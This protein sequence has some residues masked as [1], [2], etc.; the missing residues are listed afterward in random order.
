MV[1]CI[2]CAHHN[3]AAQKFCGECGAPLPTDSPSYTPPHLQRTVLT[4][5]FAIEGERKLVT[6]MFCDIA[7]S[8][9]LAASVGAEAMHGMLNRFFD[10]ALAD[11]HRYEGTINQFLG[12]G[13]M[14]LFGAPIAHED[15][16]R[17]A[18]LAALSIQQRVR[19]MD[20][21]AN[22][23]IQ[24]RM[25]L[26]TGM[27]VV[28][29]IGDNLRMDYTAVGDTTHLAARLQSRADPGTIRVAEGTR[30]AAAAHFAF[31]HLGRQ[32]LKGIA[33]PVD[34]FEPLGE[35]AGG[36]AV[37][38][39]QLAGVG[40][41]LVGRQ[42]ELAAL[43][44][45]FCEPGQRHGRVVLIRGEPG[46][47][48]S[49][50]LAEARRQ[51]PQR[52]LCLEGR[53]V[54]FGRS[55]SYW[56]FMQ[57]LRAALEITEGDAE[58]EALRKLEAQGQS[59]F[60]PQAA[61]VVPYLATLLSIGLSGEHEKRVKFLDAQAMKRQVFL[62][63]RQLFERL[64]Q[65]Q[66]V[67][68]VLEDWH[69]VDQSSVS[70]LEHLLP[71]AASEP[72]S[73][74]LTSR[75][76]PTAPLEHL[77][78]STTG[79]PGMHFEE[80]VLSPLS[81][82]HSGALIGAI[83]GTPGLPQTVHEQIQRRTAGN[84]FFIEEVIRAL[85]GDGTLTRDPRDGSWRLARP[86]A[87]VS[88]PDT[89]HALLQARID[90]LEDSVKSVL[91]LASVIG[92]SFF[93]RV[94]KSV[95]EAGDDVEGGL[96]RLE[97]EQ[98][99]QLLE[100]LPELEYVFRHAL[101]QE[102]AYD[103]ILGERRKAIH[104]SVARAIES[105]FADRRDEYA[106]LLAYHFARAE[107]WPSAQVYLLAA[108]DQAGRI[109]ADAEALEHYRQ[110]EAT[111]MKVAAR[112]LTPLLRASMERKLGQAFYG[113]GN[114]DEAVAHLTN[115]LAYLGIDYPKSRA[116]VRF[117]IARHIGAHFLRR[118][119]GRWMGTTMSADAAQEASAIA[120]SLA[121][122]DYYAD[123]DRFALDSLIALSTGERSGDLASTTRGIATLGLVLVMLGLHRL[124]RQRI[125][126]AVATA[127][128]ANV[129]EAMAGALFVRGWFEWTGGML[130]EALSS[131][132]QAASAYQSIGDLRGWAGASSTSGWVLARRGHFAQAA[133]LSREI[134]RVGEGAKDPHLA[135]WGSVCLGHLC[136]AVGP[137]QDA[138]PPLEKV[139]SLSVRTSAPRMHANAGGVLAKSLLRRGEIAQ[140]RGILAHALEVLEARGMKD[141]FF[142]EPITAYA[143]LLLMEADRSTGAAR[144]AALRA[145]KAACAKALKCSASSAAGWR[146]E[147]M[148]LRGTLAWLCGDRPAALKGWHESIAIAQAMQLP[149]DRARGL[150]EMGDR[151]HDEAQVE[152]A[153]L[154][155]EQSGARVDLAFSLH[156]LARLAADGG[157][158]GLALQRYDR[159]LDALAAVGADGRL[160]LARTEHAQVLARHDGV[161]PSRTI[162]KPLV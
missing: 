144:D 111:F 8:T 77:R 44:R 13:F 139:R 22:G 148:R 93:V 21:A 58:A 33:E 82:E 80:I 60:G 134:V 95:C 108:G 83:I 29:Q 3:P 9:P 57:V 15:H 143:E 117:A 141:M 35:K 34:V 59:L 66:P 32:T 5:R 46:A 45:D 107:D 162:A 145:A 140:A 79:L 150:L 96:G 7:N 87:E 42:Q 135:A 115:A 40:L 128:R 70:L 94:L 6:V 56:P 72:L 23:E 85:V 74:W 76:E 147:A 67:L 52:V 159:A 28:G 86:L 118:G 97:N 92:R 104:R 50:L 47:G 90:R 71:L 30:H 39:P 129:T 130:D 91:K 49:R 154:V 48:K 136:C 27:V 112:D 36:D 61:E 146:S 12:D 103:S 62:S 1:R 16:A 78:Q 152:E 131:L 38:N 98:F 121:W 81:E 73:F 153:R 101:V 53:A 14:A 125:L 106:S 75:S 69:W 138:A 26:N 116:G 110:A 119:F 63:M 89:V 31:K 2:H 68:V 17:R 124:A 20:G 51:M 114:Y 105:L 120:E 142:I 149:V 37:A 158:A 133:A 156:V 19:G 18:L 157:D 99:V 160:A 84:P 123:E 41:P 132:D 43:S 65:R 122:L 24:L 55:L 126:E 4:H 11:V 10:L 102:A 137:L 54:S 161:A 25:G 100:R 155:F 113:I 109:A 88:I 64:A 127:Q 151:T